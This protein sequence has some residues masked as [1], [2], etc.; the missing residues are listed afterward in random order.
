MIGL[1]AAAVYAG[2]MF[3]MPKFRNTSFEDRLNETIPYFSKQPP[4]VIREKIITTAKEF[5]IELVPGD[6]GVQVNGD[7]LTLDIAYDKV[8]DL[9]V[10]QKTLHF[11]SHRSGTY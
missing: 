7:R 9:K 6:I 3:A 2:F 10:W 1:V 11:S 5:D 4:D 8:V